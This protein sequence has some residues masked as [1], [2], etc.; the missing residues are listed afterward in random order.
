[1]I[2]GLPIL[3][4]ISFSCLILLFIIL[5]EKY[6]KKE[7]F[8]KLE[9]IHWAT[10]FSILWILFIIL[11]ASNKISNNIEINAW[12]DFLAG[13]FAPLLFLWLVYGVFLQK[14]EFANALK[15]FTYQYDEMKVQNQQIKIQQINTWFDRNLKN[16]QTIKTSIFQISNGS[17]NSIAEVVI[18]LENDINSTTEY[19]TLDNKYF[20]IYDDLKNIYDTIIYIQTNL[21]KQIVKYEK[22]VIILDSINEM[23]KEF[24]VLFKN[25]LLDL[26]KILSVAYFLIALH[27]R[28]GYEKYSIY[29]NW[30]EDDANFNDI[31]NEIIL[32]SKNTV[33][34][35]LAEVLIK[36]KEI[37][38]DF[39][40]CKIRK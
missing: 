6:S 3:I 22:Q 27:K 36:Y 9:N 29:T 38:L 7:L 10:V 32:M 30:T 23:K 14:S 40:S 31:F 21:D 1:M 5:Y 18:E 35:I 16:I 4:V 19:I 15:S 25:E 34:E 20:N 13:F 11:I 26:R 33:N 39:K 12:G 24:V 17:F 28:P 37:N 8:S 2:V